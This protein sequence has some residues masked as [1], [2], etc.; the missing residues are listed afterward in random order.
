[1]TL[2]I[3]FLE[4]FK[5]GL[6]CFGGAF[7]MIP[8]IEEIVLAHGWLSASQFYDFIGVCE[9]TPG[10]IAVNMA[11]YVG[12]T[13]AG[14]LGSIAATCGVVMPSFIIILLIASVLKNF[15]QNRYFKGFL[16]GVKPVIVA[17][18]LSTGLILLAKNVGYVSVSA[19]QPNWVKIVIFTLLAASFF[20]A[21]KLF[22][23]KLSSISLILLA[24]ALGIGVSFLANLI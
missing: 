13:Q 9:S 20:G 5:V 8:L 23:K 2:L 10:P 14:L 15:S 21:K 3:L 17:L 4:F 24:A 19:F 7:G 12:S 1:M 6:F 22:G 16:R 18:I 11:T